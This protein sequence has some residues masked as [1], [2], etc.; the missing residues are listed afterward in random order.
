[1]CHIQAQLRIQASS[2]TEQADAELYAVDLCPQAVQ[3]LGPAPVAVTD[4]IELFSVCPKS[5]QAD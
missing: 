2:V 5:M 3:L 4:A 1:M